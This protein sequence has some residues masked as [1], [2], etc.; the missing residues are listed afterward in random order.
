MTFLTTSLKLLETIV[1]SGQALAYLPDYYADR[2]DVL[3]IR[4]T[5]CPYTCL[6]KIKLVAR[7]PKQTGWLNQLF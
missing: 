2:L 7:R 3:P 6:Q 4:V 5:G 1:E